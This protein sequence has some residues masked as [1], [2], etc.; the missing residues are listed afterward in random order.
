MWFLANKR[1]SWLKRGQGSVVVRGS[2]AK[3][4]TCKTVSSEKT[5]VVKNFTN[6]KKR[7]KKLKSKAQG[8]G[9][10]P[11]PPVGPPEG[12]ASRAKRDRWVSRKSLQ[13]PQLHCL[14]P[15]TRGQRS[16][17][18]LHPSIHQQLFTAAGLQM[19]MT[20]NGNSSPPK[21]P[22]WLWSCWIGHQKREVVRNESC[23]HYGCLLQWF[24]T[25]KL[26]N[27]YSYYLF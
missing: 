23:D 25:H 7:K 2:V 15:T 3:A 22:D 21:T 19:W 8:A 11:R 27:N 9:P 14:T 26:I 20:A 12:W 16:M 10:W 18:H 17:G 4:E 1:Y 6:S 13:W 5:V 24:Q